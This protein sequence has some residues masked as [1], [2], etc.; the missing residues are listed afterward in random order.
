MTQSS[1]LSLSA[2]SKERA[3]LVREMEDHGWTGRITTNG[4]AFMLSPDGTTTTSVAPKFGS[5]TRASGNS[6]AVFKRWLKQQQQ[7]TTA[8]EPTIHRSIPE[9]ETE[10]KS[11]PERTT[12]VDT[13]P[14][15]EPEPEPAPV[16]TYVCSDC[17]RGFAGNQ[18]LSVHRVRV[19][20]KVECPVCDRQ[21]PPGNL[22]R[23]QRNHFRGLELTQLMRQLY[24]TQR[25][26]EHLRSEVR[27]W[28]ILAE[29]TEHAYAALQERVRAALGTLTDQ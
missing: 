14:E 29:D 26:N 5:P 2:F 25:E 4:H 13:A 1:R 16:R 18:P 15:P 24:E 9:P 7:E 3:A 21:L 27:E 12:P 28:Q 23:H 22:P 17:G 8:P 11:E 19:H 6:R 20:V 10:L